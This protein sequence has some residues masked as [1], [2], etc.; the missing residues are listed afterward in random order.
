MVCWANRL[1]ACGMRGL[2]PARIAAVA[3]APGLAVLLEKKSRRMEL[4]LYCSC[5]VRPLVPLAACA[6]ARR[7]SMPCALCLMMIADDD[8]AQ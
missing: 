8:A 5:R 1:D 7:R 2:T 4:A 6:A 3:W